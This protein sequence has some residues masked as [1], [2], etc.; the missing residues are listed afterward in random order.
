MAGSVAAV[1]GAGSWGT[2]LAQLLASCSYETVRLWARRPERAQAIEQARENELY[3][4]GIRLSDALKATADL[5]HAL[6]EA[7]LVLLVVPSH[8]M[9]DVMQQ[10][11]ELLPRDVPVV[12]ASKG[13]EIPALMLVSQVLEEVLPAHHHRFL[14]YLSGP[15]FAKE[16]AQGAPTAVSLAG[17]DAEVVEQ[18]Q[19]RLTTDRFRV[20]ST[21]D[22]IGVELGGAL[23]NV[24]AIAA[25]ILDGLGFGYNSRAALMTRGLAEIGRLSAQLGGNPLTTAGLSGMGD[26]VLTCTGNLS[27]NRSVGVQLGQG[28]SLDEILAGMTMVAE[29]VRTAKSAYELAERE[30]VPMPIVT[31]V[32][33]ILYEGRR[34]E[35]AVQELMTRPPRPERG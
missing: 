7:Q 8:C 11:A 33:R 25:G 15:S 22:V 24:M 34:P 4:P 23:K 19:G 32:Y 6:R 2:A 16:V 5:Q 12:S 30:H 18:V 14:T 29:G 20:Y 1:L 17:R 9:R 28:R 10:A 21:D 31:E 26:L 27:R 3:L 13:I 35:E